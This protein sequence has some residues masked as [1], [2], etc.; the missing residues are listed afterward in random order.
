[1]ATIRVK[2]ELFM[3]MNERLRNSSRLDGFG[4]GLLHYCRRVSELLKVKFK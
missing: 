1:M 2:F 4:K 3:H